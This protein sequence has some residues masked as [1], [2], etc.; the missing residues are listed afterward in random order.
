MTCDLSTGLCGPAESE[1]RVRVTYVTDPICSACWAMEP[2]WRSARLRFGDTLDVQHVYGGLLPSWDGFADPANGIHGY[3][4]VAEHW[5][6]MAEHVGQATAVS[7]WADDPIL[8]SFPASMVMTAVRLI[9]PEREESALRA[10][11][12]QLFFHGRNI[13][14]PEIWSAAVGVDPDLVAQKLADGSA[15]REFAADLGRARALGVS[16]FPTLV[17][18]SGGDRFALRGVQS[19]ERLTAV[20]GALV[21]QVPDGRPRELAE[22]ITTL[23]SGTTAEYAAVLDLPEQVLVAGLTDAGLRRIDLPG[24]AAW[25]S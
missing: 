10:L 21:G 20:L 22:A 25:L 6:E 2:A 13:G 15:K 17:V 24:G 12:E 9:D 7:V 18:E 4:D 5:R 8:S 23:G 14:R 16:G 1:Q 3:E 11:R 19:P